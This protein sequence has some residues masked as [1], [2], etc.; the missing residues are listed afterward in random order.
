[1]VQ[2][3]ESSSPLKPVIMMVVTQILNTVM[4]IMYKFVTVTGTN[5]NVFVA[6]RLMFSAAFM[7]PLALIL[8]RAALP[9]NLYILS[10]ALT[11]PT[12]LA[13]INNLM[14]ATTFVVALCFRQE[15]LTMRNS[16]IA[17]M[18]G[19]VV[20][21]GGAMLFIFYRG[22][23]FTFWATHIDL[24]QQ[25]YGTRSVSS[26]SHMSNPALGLLAGFGSSL[27]FSLWLVMQVKMS[28]SYPCP[29]SSTALMAIMGS[30]QS[31][32]FALCV[33]RDW[34]HWRMGWDIRLW[35][36]AY[37]G[38]VISGVAVVVMSWCVQKRGPLF[39]SIFSPLTLLMVAFASSLLLGEN[40]SLGSVLG[41][42]L[43]VCGL[44]MVLWGKSK[45]G[46]SP[47]VL[48][49]LTTAPLISKSVDSAPVQTSVG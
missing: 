32:I 12:F 3:H 39:V 43:I 22:P 28:K 27:C 8:E 23:V 7:V 1:M 29:Y 10:L 36:A 46:P 2:N 49:S 4:N 16:G 17:K 15:K 33:E 19:T 48:P 25:Y 9:Q 26:S 38:I 18:V 24:L 30:I 31:V 5:L 20:G 44:Y 35:T 47:L 21:I 41:G 6:Y 40:F 14:P 37:S 45:E 11:S 13:A 42:V 34:N